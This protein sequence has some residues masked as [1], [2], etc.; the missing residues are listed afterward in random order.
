MNTANAQRD[1]L[2]TIGVR[3][4]NC[5]NGFRSD[6]PESFAG[7]TRWFHNAQLFTIVK[8]FF[9]IFATILIVLAQGGDLFAQ[10]Y[11]E[12]Y[13]SKLILGGNAAGITPLTILAPAS[14]LSSY[15]LTLPGLVGAAGQTLITLDANGNLG[16]RSLSGSNTGDVTLAGTGTYLS[17]AG[18]VISRNA[19]DLS[20]VNNVTSV[21]PIA[22]GG[23]NSGTALSGTPRPVVTTATAIVENNATI[24]NNTLP[25][26][27]GSNFANSSMADDGTTVTTTENLTLSG[28]K[29]LRVGTASSATGSVAF[30]SSS[31]SYLTTLQAD[32]ATS[33]VTY[34][35]PATNGTSGQVLA[36]DG[37]NPAQ[38]SWTTRSSGGAAIIAGQTSTNLDNNSNTNYYFPTGTTDG[39]NTDLNFIESE[40][41]M[42]RSGVITNLYVGL[43]YSPGTSKSH[44]FTVRNITTSEELSTITVT[45]GNVTGNSGS[46]TL[47]VSAGDLI[48]VKHYATSNPRDTQAVWSFEIQ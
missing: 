18:Q 5:G 36:T 29:T 20:N 39:S 28:A 13:G 7:G 15:S 32:N 47:S 16:W 30:A 33:A 6:N 42:P 43:S 4:K 48:V 10:A 41:I 26:W 22:N 40:M 9:H 2:K 25:K 23:R 34:K 35:L 38:L 21:L 45:D 8:R 27:S 17:I 14:G 46:S 1:V 12:R 44:S 11:A 37:S 19:I 3:F 24:S 31:S